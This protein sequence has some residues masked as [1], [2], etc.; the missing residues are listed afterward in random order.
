MPTAAKA[1]EIE[2]LRDSFTGAKVALVVNFTALTVEEVTTLRSKLRSKGAK[3]K[4]VKNT[5]AKI[6]AEG[7]GMEGVKDAF[8]GPIMVTFGYDEDISAPA[9]EILDFAKASKDRM[10]VVAGL[11]EGS[12][13]DA[14]GVKVLAE[15][16]PKPVVQAMLLG[17]FQA[18]A[19]NFLGLMTNVPRSIMNVMTNYAEKQEKG[20]A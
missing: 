10:T 19:K 20:G 11:V 16:P 18:P 3:L 7:T 5:L 17:L 6:A 8:T 13:V 1:A 15:M 2:N 12:V 14:A 9:K 4:V